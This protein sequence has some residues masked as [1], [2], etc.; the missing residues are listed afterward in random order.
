MTLSLKAEDDAVMSQSSLSHT[1]TDTD[2]RQ[3]I[4]GA[5]LSTPART[6]SMT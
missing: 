2:R 5:L 6:R 1:V 3:Q 4:D